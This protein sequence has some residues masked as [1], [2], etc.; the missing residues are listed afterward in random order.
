MPSNQRE[1]LTRVLKSHEDQ[2]ATVP[3]LGII[4]QSELCR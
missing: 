2:V 4:G 1:A 3:A